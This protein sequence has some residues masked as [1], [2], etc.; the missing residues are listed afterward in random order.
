MSSKIKVGISIVIL[1]ILAICTVTARRLE[2]SR[3]PVVTVG[4]PSSGTIDGTEY[5]YVV[6]IQVLNEI[7]AD[8]DGTYSAMY[9]VPY[10]E[11]TVHGVEYI[12]NNTSFCGVLAMDDEHAALTYAEEGMIID[13]DKQVEAG[14]T[15]VMK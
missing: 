11:N 4:I 13:S 2:I 5:D 3:M 12:T 9:F 6:P 14:Q 7:E 8:D 10:E 1:L 15:V